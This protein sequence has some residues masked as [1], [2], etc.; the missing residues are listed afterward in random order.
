VALTTKSELLF[1]WLSPVPFLLTIVIPAACNIFFNFSPDVRAPS[2]IITRVGI[3]LSALFFL[4]GLYFSVRDRRA[5]QG[6][7]RL[8]LALATLFA[9]FPAAIFLLALLERWVFQLI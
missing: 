7:D 4:A 8:L 6:S 3:A 9:G 5:K 1:M 2:I